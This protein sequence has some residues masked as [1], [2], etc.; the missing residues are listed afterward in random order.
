MEIKQYITL[1]I[2]KNDFTF[3]F[4]MPHGAT[5]GSAIDSAYEML[6][7]LNELSQ[8]SAQSLKA[9][10]QVEPEIMFESEIARAEGE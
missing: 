7:K 1:E 3:S 5:W 10:Q 4:Q 9:Q 2:Q 8:Q 6:Q